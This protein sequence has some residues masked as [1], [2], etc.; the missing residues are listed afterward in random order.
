MKKAILLFTLGLMSLTV[1]CQNTV[2]PSGKNV[3][4]KRETGSFNNLDVSGFFK[5]ILEKADKN[6]VV[7]DTDAEFAPFI[8]TTVNGGTLSVRLKPR[9]RLKNNNRTSVTVTVY[10]TNL[11]EVSLSGSGNISGSD[12]L[13]NDCSVELTGSGSINLNVNSSIAKVEVTGSGNVELAG[14]A[15]TLECEVTGSGSFKGTNLKSSHATL[16]V[17]GSGNIKANASAYI[18]ARI[19]GSG[20]IYYGGNPEKKDLSTTGSGKINAF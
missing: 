10:Y 1:S 20:N 5:V 4:E 11:N 16:S 9:T 7:V 15:D 18:K 3:K 12:A 14:K 8:E 19:T 17:Q 2:Q 6:S 13:Q